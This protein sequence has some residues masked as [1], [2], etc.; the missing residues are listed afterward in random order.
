MPVRITLRSTS[1]CS[2]YREMLRHLVESP[3][4]DSIIICSGYIQEKRW[5]YSILDDGLLESVKQGCMQGRVITIAG[6]EDEEWFKSYRR[7]IERLRAA[8]VNVT[9][10]VAPKDNWHAKIALRMKGDSPIAALIG[11]SNLT[12]RA[13]EIGSE[14]IKWNF[15]AD[16][17]I[18]IDE[19]GLNA[20]FGDRLDMDVPFGDFRLILDPHVRQPN[21]LEQL[22]HL[23][24]YL[25]HSGVRQMRE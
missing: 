3:M 19:P 23:Q 2:P 10:C 17:L 20:Y 16:V 15:E 21:E 18:W 6:T 4:A 8:Q 14:T 11:S 9:P 24:Q 22:K 5:N 25:R 13:W 1:T 7:F 12:R